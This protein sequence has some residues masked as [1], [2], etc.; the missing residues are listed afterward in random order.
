MMESKFYF[1]FRCLVDD[2]AFPFVSPMAPLGLMVVACLAVA[3]GTQ[4]Q[5]SSI[6]VEINK[7]IKIINIKIM[8]INIEKNI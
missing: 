6:L 8:I 7:L 1:F 2:I 5:P 4:L 3:L